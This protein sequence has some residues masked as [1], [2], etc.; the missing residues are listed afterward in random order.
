MAITIET[1]S[2]VQ[3]FTKSITDLQA[4]KGY[5]HGEA[6]MFLAGYLESKLV[7][8]IDDMPKAKKRQV[9]A[10]IARDTIRKEAQAELLSEV[11]YN[12]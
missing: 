9:L 1:R 10:D 7:G 3:C 4:A 6:L 8:I 2:A 5:T 11:T 12:D